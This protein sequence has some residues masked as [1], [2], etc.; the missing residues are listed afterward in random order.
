MLLLFFFFLMIRRPPRS[1]L[2]PYTTLFR[3][4]DGG[5]ATLPLLRRLYADGRHGRSGSDV[6]QEDGQLGQGASPPVQG[7]NVGLAPQ[8]LKRNQRE[9]LFIRLLA[10]RLDD[11]VHV[12]EKEVN[13]DF[14]RSMNKI[15]FDKTVT[16]DPETFA[17]V[18]L[19]EKEEEVVPECGKPISR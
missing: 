12:L 2:F 8:P 16:N 1:T 14:R 3:S 10:R 9:I 17:F 19:P 4:A 13:I 11:Y 15:V 5:S 7:Q 6:V 18:Q